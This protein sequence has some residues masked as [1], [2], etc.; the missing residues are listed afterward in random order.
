MWSWNG[1]ASSTLSLEI[2]PKMRQ[3]RRSPVSRRRN[4]SSMPSGV[5][6]LWCFA[7][8]SEIDLDQKVKVHHLWEKSLTVLLLL[9][10]VVN[11]SNWQKS[12]LGVTILCVQQHEIRHFTIILA[13]ISCRQTIKYVNGG[14][15]ATLNFESR[16]T[17]HIYNDYND[18]VHCVP[19]H[20]YDQINN[21][22]GTMADAGIFSGSSISL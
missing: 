22:L 18:C 16:Q 14:S 1:R 19:N 4:R 12:A 6:T 20:I 13:F 2:L 7:P 17:W 8:L 21:R 9:K 3:M 5:R 15:V 10:C 11:L